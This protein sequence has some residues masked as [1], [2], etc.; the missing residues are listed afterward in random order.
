[1]DPRRQF[2]GLL[3]RIFSDAVVDD[4]EHGELLDFLASGALTPPERAEVVSEFVAT[5]WKGT[6]ADGVVSDREKLRLREIVKVL[7]LDATTLP[8]VWATIVKEP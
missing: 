4:A 1:M 3:A 2:K 8:E 6:S 7:G 5:T